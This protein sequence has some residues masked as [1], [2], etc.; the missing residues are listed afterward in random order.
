MSQDCPVLGRTCP[1]E[2]PVSIANFQSYDPLMQILHSMVNGGDHAYMMNLVNNVSPST[3]LFVYYELLNNTPSLDILANACANDMFYNSMIRD[4][5]VENSYGIKSQSVRDALEQRYSP[6]TTQEMA[7]IESAAQSISDFEELLFQLSSIKMEYYTLMNAAL[8]Y[9]LDLEEMSIDDV[10]SYLTEMNDYYSLIRLCM[11]ELE[12]GDFTA[13][14]NVLSE[15]QGLG[16]NSEEITDFEIYYS[17]VRQVYDG[18]DGD[19]YRL[20]RD[21]K[22]TLS[23]I[24]NNESYASYLAKALIVTYFEEGF[25]P[26]YLVASTNSQRKSNIETQSSKVGFR[27]Y[28][29]PASDEI[30]VIIPEDCTVKVVITN[31]QGKLLLSKVLQ[32]GSAVIEVGGLS[33]G[34]YFVSL[35]ENNR[36]IKTE[37]LIKN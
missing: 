2:P 3:R 9:Y 25:N 10:K 12:E 6:L 16:V 17:I 27:L 1:I 31:I 34:L 19:F 35:Y 24:S 8:N 32:D 23:T 5:L 21:D 29:N 36:L 14:D 18:Y 15:I 33:D 37:K 7:Q 4:I 26:V 30:F 28:P 13:A 20:N 11:I 22:T